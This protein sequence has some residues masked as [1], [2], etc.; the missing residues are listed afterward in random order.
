M[1]DNP[2]T[3]N[4]FKL[5]LEEKAE[6][7]VGRTQ[8]DPGLAKE[9]ADDARRIVV[10]ELSE[11]E[12]HQ[13]YHQSYL[14]EFGVDN[15]PS[16]L[17]VGTGGTSGGGPREISGETTPNP[18]PGNDISR[19]TF[20]K[21]AGGGAVALAIG[22]S[23]VSRI[24]S[25]SAHEEDEHTPAGAVQMGMVI[26]LERC[27][28]CLSCV[29]AC[30]RENNLGT[31][32]VHWIYVFAYEDESQDGTNFLVRPCQHCSNP[33][34]VKVCP[35]MA[36]HKREKDGL[37]LTDYDICIGC[38]YCEVACPY[39]V[40]YFQWAEP[41]PDE[42]FRYSR[43]DYRG[44][45]VDGNPPR[46]VMGKCTYCPQRQDSEWKKGTAAC[47]LACPHDAIHFGNMN[48]PE[49]APMRYLKKRREQNG[50]KLSTFR[51]LED[52]GTK[53]NI[54]YIGNQPS[55]AA[56]QVTG[57]TSYEDWDVV[58]ERRAVLE[59]PRPWFTRVFG[60]GSK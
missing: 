51:L 3:S 35:V 28:G 49:S 5:G 36:R 8:Y 30:H 44:R 39:G 23:L 52:M 7:L 34:C 2:N 20:L 15:R 12:F 21:L 6:R 38:R 40:N 56:K 43:T 48:D 60:G 46:G 24:S 4:P 17:G 10:G 11:D 31:A 45:W 27:D 9:A 54:I 32:G 26:D 14:E 16:K 53:P 1:T 29:D 41:E 33:V 50:G 55:R 25:V 59:G 19:R 58:D 37:V 13:K 22:S 18:S 47:Q 57:P 42:G